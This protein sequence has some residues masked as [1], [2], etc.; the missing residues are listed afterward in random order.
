MYTHP[1]LLAP[2]SSIQH[3][4][5]TASGGPTLKGPTGTVGG[6]PGLMPESQ[7]SDHQK[8]LPCVLCLICTSKHGNPQ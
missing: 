8:H 3:L 6:S 5:S 1:H 2:D 7:A 4:V